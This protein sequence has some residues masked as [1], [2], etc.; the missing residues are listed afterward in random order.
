ML[1]L[2]WT[3]DN[4]RPW[5]ICD[6]CRPMI[7]TVW[8]PDEA[9]PLPLHPSCYCSYFPT[10]MTVDQGEPHPDLDTLPPVTR[11]AWIRYA[12]YLLRLG[13]DLVPWLIPLY[14]EAVEYNRQREEEGGDSMPGT[15]PT[16]PTPPDDPTAIFRQLLRK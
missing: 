1:R 10:D 6:L 5:T 15:D 9:P 16:E 8:E 2:I 13:L 12:A 14:L 7:G 4:P 3:N 11:R